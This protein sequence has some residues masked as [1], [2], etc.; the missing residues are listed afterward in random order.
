MATAPSIAGPG[1]AR[2]C[3]HGDHAEPGPERLRAKPDPTGTGVTIGGFVAIRTGGTF[4]LANLVFN[5][6]MNLAT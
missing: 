4:R 1:V 5:S 3:Q 6:I 2:H